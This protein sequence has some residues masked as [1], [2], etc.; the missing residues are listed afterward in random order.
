MEISK[1][2]ILTILAIIVIFVLLFPIPMSRS[3]E[4]VNTIPKSMEWQVTW[5]IIT[6]DKQW[7]PDVG[8]QTFTSS[9][10]SYDWGYGSVYGGYDDGIGFVAEASFCQENDGLYRFN[11]GSD[12]GIQLYIDGTLLIDVWRDQLYRES[13]VELMIGPGWHTLKIK[14][15]EWRNAARVYFNVDKGDLFTWAETEVKTVTETVYVSILEYL[16]K[17]GTA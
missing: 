2:Q 9:T 7:G 4:E 6:I 11:A 5:K 10:F 13:S 14:Y 15:Y 1:I 12:D 16:M 3:R 8:N 17:G